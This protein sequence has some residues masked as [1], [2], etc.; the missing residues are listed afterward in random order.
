MAENRSER[1]IIDVM[2][3]GSPIVDTLIRVEESVL[4]T[5]G[6]EK[7]GMELVD[8]DWMA[9]ALARIEGQQIEAPGGSAGNTAAGL[10]RLGARV[11]FLG[12]VG[13]DIGG[14]FYVDRFAELGGDTQ[15]F[16]QGDVANGRC[17]SLV[18][19]DSERTM[20]TNLGAAM[21]LSPD[22]VSAADFEGVRHAHIEGYLLFNPDLM[23]K[24]L[25]SAVATGCTVSLDLASFE[26]VNATRDRL[27]G[28]LNQSVDL[29]FANEEEASAY[30]G[31]KGSPR[32]WAVEL[33]KITRVAAVKVGKDGAYIASA[34]GV[35]HVPAQRVERVIDTTGAGD[36]WAAGFLYGWTRGMPLDRC[37]RIGSLLGAEVIQ[38]LGADIPA[39]TWQRICQ[40]PV[41]AG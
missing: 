27:P 1:V 5:I 17:L 26:V 2:G 14:K 40:D 13:N 39:D 32:E 29:V 37:A 41:V 30:F 7:G 15:R 22:E 36:L 25:A 19:P 4:A 12:K 23:D 11:S 16:K 9:A 24:V 6:G 21:T 35:D 8:G 33:A 28:I 18:T 20:R 10:A 31:G 3:V 34:G 38:I